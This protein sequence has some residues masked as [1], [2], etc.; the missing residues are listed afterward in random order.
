[1]NILRGW[2]HKQGC[3]GIGPLLSPY[4]DGRT[5]PE[6]TRLVQQHLASCAD[7]QLELEQLRLV[8][9]GLQTLPQVRP[10]RSFA[11]AA[12]PARVQVPP[13]VSNIVYLRRL[14][15]SLAASLVLLFAFALQAGL[16]AAF[17]SRA[18]QP[19]AA[20]AK[21]TG[22]AANGDSG[23]ATA[24]AARKVA[25]QAAAAPTA[26]TNTAPAQA[27]AA[28]PAPA[29]TEPAD[30]AKAASAPAAPAAG[31]PLAPTPAGAILAPATAAQVPSPV[32]PQVA[33]QSP[34][35]AESAPAPLA[36]APQSTAAPVA[37]PAS[38]ATSAPDTQG[39]AGVQSVRSFF[40]EAELALA[41]GLLLV[42]VAI[43]LGR[44][45]V[46]S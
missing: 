34:A 5:R 38:S 32:P 37:P 2:Q 44:R 26:E 42:A 13:T 4:I 17:V 6:E 35:P 21:V 3:E 23:R 7:C 24:A 29:A 16:P 8:V 22:L 27:L 31:A 30:A 19:A 40:W 1:M 33:G 43:I 46:G 14:A 18:S 9:Q 36:R 45:S 15:V 12:P 28:A 39:E 25:P 10:S 41:L 11:L 20:P